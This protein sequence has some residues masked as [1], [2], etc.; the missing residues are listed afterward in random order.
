MTRLLLII[1][2][3]GLQDISPTSLS[4]ICNELSSTFIEKSF[5]KCGI[6]AHTLLS[7]QKVLVDLEKLHTVLENAF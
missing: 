7:N 4:Q 3:S 6:D 1:I 5:S 2:T